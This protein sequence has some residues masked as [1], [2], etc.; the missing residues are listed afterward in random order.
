MIWTI[1]HSTHPIDE[2]IA[3][4]Q[5]YQIQQLVDIRTIPRS[6]HNPQFNRDALPAS[7]LTAALGYHHMAG[8][9]GLRRPR[10]DS[11]N[12]DWR[13]SSFRGYADYMQ[14]SEFQINLDYLIE[15]GASARTVN[16]CAEALQWRCHRSLVADALFVRGIPVDHIQ[17]A[18]RVQPHKLTSFAHQDGTQIIYGAQRQLH[19]SDPGKPL[20]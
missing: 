8:L 16:M 1:G 10:P 9:G 7:L 18:G 6:R 11:V 2:F 12:T 5:A 3:M 14:T 20:T 15:L 19:E 4:L 17:S 13:N